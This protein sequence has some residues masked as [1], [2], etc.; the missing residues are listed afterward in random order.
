MLTNRTFL[1]PPFLPRPLPFWPFA[2]SFPLPFFFCPFF[3]LPLPLALERLEFWLGSREADFLGLAGAAA[4]PDTWPHSRAG[5]GLGETRLAG[6]KRTTS[7]VA[8]AAKEALLA[9]GVRS[10]LGPSTL[11]TS[12]G[13]IARS[14]VRASSVGFTILL[15]L[16]LCLRFFFTK[17]LP[18][19]LGDA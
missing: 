5:N 13:A 15:F 9:G 16:P 19:G 2:W 12:C 17:G 1:P 6:S 10:L 4:A 7:G 11:A 8:G 18:A 3:P 14:G